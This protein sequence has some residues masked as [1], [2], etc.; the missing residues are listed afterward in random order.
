MIKNLWNNNKDFRV[1]V[2]QVF[3]AIVAFGTSYITWLDNS[4][5]PVFMLILNQVSKYINTVYF[6]DIWVNKSL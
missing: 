3:N 2:W 1:F 5:V 4:Y 6:N